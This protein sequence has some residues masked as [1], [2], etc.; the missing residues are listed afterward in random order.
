MM[1]DVQISGRVTG[2]CTNHQIKADR[3]DDGLAY[4]QTLAYAHVCTFAYAPIQILHSTRE[5][6][7][8]FPNLFTAACCVLMLSA[9]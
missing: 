9:F 8:T 3:Q 5:T 6:V 2:V 4:T 7:E 1:T